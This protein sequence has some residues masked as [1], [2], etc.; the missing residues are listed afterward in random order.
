M[1]VSINGKM[2]LR[3]KCPPKLISLEG[4]NDLE[5]RR[6]YSQEEEEEKVSFF[7]PLLLS[8]I[9][10][11][12][13]IDCLASLLKSLKGQMRAEL[14][15]ADGLP[16]KMA[17]FAALPSCHEI[18]KN[19]QVCQDKDIL[20]SASILASALLGASI[21]LSGS[22]TIS[23]SCFPSLSLRSTPAKTSS[24]SLKMIPSSAL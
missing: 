9:P 21:R 4:I 15:A 17:A 23:I 3:A 12:Q 5:E 6:L 11:P 7:C 10:L 18:K 24:S 20:L 8:T 22:L 16:A 14:C 19:A 2:W 1:K 13:K